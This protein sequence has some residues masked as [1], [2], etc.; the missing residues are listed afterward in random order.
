MAKNWLLRLPIGRPQPVAAFSRRLCGGTAARS[1]DVGGERRSPQQRVGRGLDHGRQAVA[2]DPALEQLPERGSVDRVEEVVH[3]ELQVP[4][5]AL[6]A[7]DLAD[8]LLQASHC[9]VRALAAAVG[10]AVVHEGGLEDRLELRHQPVVHH[11]IGE[12]RRVDLARLRPGG[13]EAGRRPGRPGAGAELGLQL[14]QPVDPLR[15]EAQLVHA[16]L[17]PA[18]GF[19]PRR[20]E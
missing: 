16:G 6:A 7:V 8:E 15:V 2:H 10:E 3:V 1:A 11:A 18:A 5:A 13:N 17:F 19:L 9:R 14:Q 20:V 4:A 12:V